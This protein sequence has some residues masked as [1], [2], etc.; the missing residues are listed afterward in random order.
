MIILE[1]LDFTGRRKTP[2][3]RQAEASECGLA[4]LAMVACYHGM[5][6]DLITL[7]QHFPVSLK[8]S[9]L[10]QLMAIAEELG[11]AARPQR[12]EVDELAQIALPAIL[13]WNLDHFVV[14]TRVRQTFGGNRY[15]LND[16][17]LGDRVLGEAEFARQFTGVVLELTKSERFQPKVER[18]RLRISQLWSRMEGFWPT[19]RQIFLLSVALQLLTL[20]APFFLQVS[21]D[22]VL[23]SLDADLLLMLALGFGGVALV[24]VLT[25]WV[26]ALVLLRLGT[27]LSYQ[28]VI[29]LFRHLMRLPL[30]WFEKRHV[31]DVV[32]RFGSTKSISDLLSQGLIA[33]LVDGIM[34]LATFRADVRLFASTFAVGADGTRFDGLP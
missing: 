23:P 8:G 9:N 5:N 12:G 32:S 22:T 34:A 2:V 17:A 28:V 13:H 31:G 20:A 27:S 30:Q 3:I 4:C 29:N 6:V 21:I 14:L 24:S 19:F 10:K 7:R 18:T 26:R 15:H 25:T 1:Q 11:F 33:A 16:P